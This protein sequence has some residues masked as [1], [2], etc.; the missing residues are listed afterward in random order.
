M[1]AYCRYEKSVQMDFVAFL[2]FQLIFERF[3]GCKTKWESTQLVSIIEHNKHSGCQFLSNVVVTLVFFLLSKHSILQNFKTEIVVLSIF[4]IQIFVHLSF[5]YTFRTSNSPI[6][7]W[8][9]SLVSPHF[10]WPCVVHCVYVFMF[11]F[12]PVYFDLILERRKKTTT[13]SLLRVFE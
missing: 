7:T 12:Y 4:L 5:Y 9:C 11:T 6:I 13:L 2:H 3:S 1:I 10:N 8:L